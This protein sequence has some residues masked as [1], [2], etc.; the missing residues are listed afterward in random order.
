MYSKYLRFLHKHKLYDKNIFE[1]INNHSVIINYNKIYE[2]NS[3]GCSVVVDEHGR[4]VEVIPVIPLLKNDKM[5]VIS[6]FT[7]VQAMMLIPNI[8]RKYDERYYN[9]VIPIVFLELYIYENNSIYLSNFEKQ[10][11]LK[12]FNQSEE[13]YEKAIQ[14]KDFLINSYNKNSNII[15]SQARRIRTKARDYLKKWKR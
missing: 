13:Q 2:F 12:M 9:K 7:Y 6:I 3:F 1:Y 4:L 11:I 5:V 8:G 14:Y 15:D 10:I